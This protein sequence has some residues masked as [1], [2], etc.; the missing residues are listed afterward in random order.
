MASRLRLAVARYFPKTADP[1]DGPA[2]ADQPSGCPDWKAMIGDG[3][4]Q[5]VALA[6]NQ[7]FSGPSPREAGEKAAK[8]RRQV[9]GSREFP[10]TVRA[11]VRRGN[12]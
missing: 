2:T 10:S 11:N 6:E 8:S 4:L 3:H 7:V 5:A 1:A 12:F 9:V